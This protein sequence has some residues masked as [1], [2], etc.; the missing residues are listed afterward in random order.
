MTRSLSVGLIKSLIFSFKKNI[1]SKIL[2]SLAHPSK[3]SLTEKTSHPVI[4]GSL[5]LQEG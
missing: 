3:S 4:K 2:L 1:I 5:R